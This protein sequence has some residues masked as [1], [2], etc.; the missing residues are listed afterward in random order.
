MIHSNPMAKSPKLPKE[1]KKNDSPVVPREVPLQFTVDRSIATK[2]TTNL[3]IQS[4]EQ[5][6]LLSFFEAV[7]PIIVGSPQQIEEALKK[8]TSLEAQCVA[9]LVVTPSKFAEFV[10][11]LNQALTGIRSA[12]G[13]K[14]SL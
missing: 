7:P 11:I 2:H 9:R 3:V 5:E 12:K 13:G 10:Q 6:I 14:D 1:L 4:S 8:A